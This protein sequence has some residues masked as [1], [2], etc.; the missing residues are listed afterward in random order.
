MCMAFSLHYLSH[1]NTAD[2]N[3]ICTGHK[4]D[5]RTQTSEDTQRGQFVIPRRGKHNL[6]IASGSHGSVPTLINPDLRAAASPGRTNSAR[7]AGAHSYI[8]LEPGW[9]MEGQA[10]ADIIHSPKIAPKGAC[11][12]F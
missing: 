7:Q 2:L 4:H 8:S 3:Y 5:A 9:D 11:V 12:Y 6:L 10:A 1:Y